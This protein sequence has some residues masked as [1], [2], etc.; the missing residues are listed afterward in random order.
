MG[1]STQ[2]LLSSLAPFVGHAREGPLRGVG[3]LD[4]YLTDPSSITLPV[5]GNGGLTTTK[6]FVYHSML[7]ENHPS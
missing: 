4:S 2:G 5:K 6:G 3:I 7:L 1:L